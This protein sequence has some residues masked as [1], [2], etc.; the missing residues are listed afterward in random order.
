MKSA[1]GMKLKQGKSPNHFSGHELNRGMV[2]F[3]K[4]SDGFWV[5]TVRFGDCEVTESTGSASLA[6]C[7]RSLRGQV[8]NLRNSIDRLLG[9]R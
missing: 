3:E 6:A 1:F 2:H 9:D 7:Y 8:K 5:G 4:L